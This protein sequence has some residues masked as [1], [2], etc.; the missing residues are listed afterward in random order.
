MDG[1]ELNRRSVA[2]GT[3]NHG[4]VASSR[5]L[6]LILLT[7]ARESSFL[8]YAGA[9]ALHTVREIDRSEHRQGEGNRCRTII[10]KLSSRKGGRWS[11]KY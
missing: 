1:I 8:K 7:A 6:L 10:T 2:E 3:E 9:L 4:V 5:V 11:S